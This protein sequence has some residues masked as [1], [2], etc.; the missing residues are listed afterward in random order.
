MTRMNDER[1]CENKQWLNLKNWGKTCHKTRLLYFY[2]AFLWPLLGGSPGGAEQNLS[3]RLDLRTKV[4][5]CCLNK[6]GIDPVQ[7]IVFWFVVSTHLKKYWSNWESSPNTLNGTESQQTPKALSKLRSS[8]QILMFRGPFSGSCW[9]FLELNYIECDP[10]WFTGSQPVSWFQLYT[11]S[12]S[13]NDI[14]MFW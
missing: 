4:G 9:G 6:S 14:L 2:L 13:R 8:Y 1:F 11:S 10:F 7:W 3:P 12:I 5:F